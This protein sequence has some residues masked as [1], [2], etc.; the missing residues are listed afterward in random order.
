[1]THNIGVRIDDKLLDKI[2][3]LKVNISETVREALINEVAKRE[4]YALKESLDKLQK[5]LANE[6]PDDYVRLVRESRDQR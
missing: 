2:K 1:M 6:D 5:M 3:K 4:T